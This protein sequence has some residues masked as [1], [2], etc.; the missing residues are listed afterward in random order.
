[1]G[2]V[3]SHPEQK[4]IW[5]AIYTTLDYTGRSPVQATWHLLSQPSLPL[6]MCYNADATLEYSCNHFFKFQ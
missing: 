6:Q 5:K 2:N 3:G 4:V 1:M